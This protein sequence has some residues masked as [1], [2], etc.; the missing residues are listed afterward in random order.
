MSRNH[1]LSDETV[2]RLLSGRDAP[3]VLEKERGF[4]RIFAKLEAEPKPVRR[5]FRPLVLALAG[6]FCLLALL[7]LRTPTLPEFATRGAPVTDSAAFRP[8]CTGSALARCKQGSALGFEVTGSSERQYFAAFARRPDGVVVWYLPEANGVSVRLD[9]NASSRVLDRGAR[10][11]NEEPP[12]QY[13]LYGVF[14]QQP[15]TRAQI[16]SALGDDLQGS[17]GV[18]VLR[19]SF[20]V[21]P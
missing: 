11:G 13:E 9:A 21:E 20:E 16:K 19:R 14:S 5:Y 8:L 15:L 7:L 6:S 17:R 2:A 1:K 4:S 12:G 3:S 18:S 10:L